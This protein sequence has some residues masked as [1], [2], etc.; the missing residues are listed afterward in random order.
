MSC[1]GHPRRHRP[2]GAPWALPNSRFLPPRFS[3]PSSPYSLV[4][5]KDVHV[6]L[7]NVDTSVRVRRQ[8]GDGW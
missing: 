4:K 7:E 8:M 6:A 3:I 1:T 2:T 5:E